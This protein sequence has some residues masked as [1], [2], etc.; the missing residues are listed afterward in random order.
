METYAHAFISISMDNNSI[1]VGQ[2]EQN[3]HLQTNHETFAG[4]KS[5]IYYY[6]ISRDERN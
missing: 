2:G 5:T 6:L 3:T 1:Y 4:K